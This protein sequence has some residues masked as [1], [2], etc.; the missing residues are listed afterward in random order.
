VKHVAMKVIR[1]RNSLVCWGDI[2][3]RRKKKESDYVFSEHVVLIT[4]KDCDK[5]SFVKRKIAE[6]IPNYDKY[7]DIIDAESSDGLAIIA[8]HQ[9]IE[10][11]APMPFLEIGH[12]WYKEG[13]KQAKSQIDDKI[14]WTAIASKVAKKLEEELLEI[15]EDLH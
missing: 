6:R 12:V 4:K 3:V 8:Y 7:M 5:C 11:G 10:C 1:P 15:M 9:L 13:Y 14:V 2:M